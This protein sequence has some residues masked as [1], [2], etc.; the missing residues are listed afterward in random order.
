MTGL[1]SILHPLDCQ[2]SVTLPGQP[3]EPMSHWEQ[4]RSSAIRI[5]FSGAG[6]GVA[7]IITGVILHDV[8][9][10]SLSIILGAFLSVLGLLLGLI[11]LGMGQLWHERIG[12]EEL[13]VRL[14]ALGVSLS[15]WVP[16]RVIRNCDSL[17]ALIC[18]S[19]SRSFFYPA[20]RA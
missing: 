19:T 6:A 1:S 18:A 17:P 9:F 2:G 14:D 16:S 20:S 11:L 12:S 3:S 7:L 15:G 10:L 4:R 5:S 13:P 8:G